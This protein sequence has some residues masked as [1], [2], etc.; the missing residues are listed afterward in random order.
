[1]NHFPKFFN[2]ASPVPEQS[3]CWLRGSEVSMKNIIIMI[4]IIQLTSTQTQC[5]TNIKQSLAT[6]KR[7]GFVHNS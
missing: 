6:G 4:I 1:M 2:V 3:W 5:N 7:L